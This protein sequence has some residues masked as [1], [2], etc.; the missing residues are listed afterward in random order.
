MSDFAI[1]QKKIAKNTL[2]LYSRMV[3]IMIVNFYAVRVLLQVLGVQ[4]YGIFTIA[5]GIITLFSILCNAL[6][7]TTQRFLSIA[8]IRDEEQEGKTVF[9]I[10]CLFFLCTSLILVVLAETAGLYFFK[11]KIQLPDAKIPVSLFVYQMSVL[12]IVIQSLTIP[13]FSS[14][15]AK[16]RMSAFAKIGLWEAFQ[17]LGI[18]LLL[19]YCHFQNALRVYS[20]MLA[21]SFAIVFLCYFIYCRRNFSF[22]RLCRKIDTAAAKEIFHFSL[23]SMLGASG[24]LAK[25]QGINILLN[26]FH[27]VCFNATWGITLQV[28]GGVNRFI[29]GFQQSFNPEIL[30]SQ[31][32]VDKG[33]FFHLLSSSAR[34]SFLLFWFIGSP[35]LMN[36]TYILQLWLGKD[37]CPP[38][39]ETFII[40][41]LV[42]F[43]VD[44]LSGPLWTAAEA[45]GHIMVYQ[46]VITSLMLMG[47]VA[48][49]FLFAF[50]SYPAYT[51]MLVNVLFNVF[52]LL[53]RLV[54]LKRKIPFSIGGFCKSVFCP[55]AEV[56]VL[57]IFVIFVIKRL[58]D[59]S[60]F[61]E[62]VASSTFLVICNCAIYCLFGI[63]REE[64]RKMVAMIQ[65]KVLGYAKR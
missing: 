53:F 4:D 12:C 28:A 48:G 38:Q 9:S 8:I 11:H 26:L 58:I 55:L 49:Y 63:N 51:I 54:Y 29:C 14:I 6:A 22:C 10:C 23:W 64:R 56:T 17:T 41:A 30:K 50:T 65:S 46:I 42:F 15:I 2:F 57:S 47:V 21:V 40:L 20:E 36:L 35:L 19:Q 5:M 3:L 31:S 25:T 24:N 62:V 32:N 27:G 33:T 37:W 13:F 39:I 60:T 45:I 44:C 16:E 18:V 61:L 59:T 1:D 7:R 43:L 34:Y 52:C